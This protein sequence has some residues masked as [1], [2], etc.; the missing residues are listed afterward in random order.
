MAHTAYMTYAE[1]QDFGGHEDADTFRVLEFKSRK[2][3]DYLTDCRVQ[4]MTEVPEAVKLCQL[5]LMTME[6]KAGAEAQITNPAVTSFNV[7]GYQESYGNLPDADAARSQMTGVVRS[8]LYGETDD[9]GTPLL[10]LGVSTT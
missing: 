6:A 10:Y 4:D 1:Y 7:E 3:I 5:S 8:M 9:Y 2:L